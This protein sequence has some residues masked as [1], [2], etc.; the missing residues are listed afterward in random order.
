MKFAPLAVALLLSFALAACEGP[1]GPQGPEGKQ[2]AEGQPG[3]E[4]KVG[5]AGAKGEKGDRGEKGDKGDRGD[6]GER[7]DRGVAALRMVDGIGAATCQA[8][9]VIVSA[10]CYGAKDEAA[11]TATPAPQF[12]SGDAGAAPVLAVCGE[13]KQ[14]RAFCT[15]R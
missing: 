9:E 14:V 13:S 10:Y 8:D 1:V 4:G 7:G 15:K 2:G 3:P 5:Q 11:G 6:K 12:P